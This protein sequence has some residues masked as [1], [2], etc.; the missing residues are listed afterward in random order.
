MRYKSDVRMDG[1]RVCVM[2]VYAR[3]NVSW[4]VVGNICCK[5]S[6]TALYVFM[7]MGGREGGAVGGVEMAVGVSADPGTK[8]V[9]QTMC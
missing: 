7:I 9:V 8:F 4:I 1:V 6:K 5:R 3:F 2:A